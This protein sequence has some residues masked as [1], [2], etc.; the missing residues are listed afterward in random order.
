M[1]K[2]AEDGAGT[3]TVVDDGVFAM[4][5]SGG[6]RQMLKRRCDVEHT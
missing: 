4:C 5:L 3:E 2:K 6:T 1:A